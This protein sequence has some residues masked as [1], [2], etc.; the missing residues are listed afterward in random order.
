MTSYSTNVTS[1]P[2]M[3]NVLFKVKRHDVMRYMLQ[4]RFTYSLTHTHSHTYTHECTI[5]R[6]G[7]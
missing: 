4:D 5:S 2:A 7:R 3:H 6:A 1:F